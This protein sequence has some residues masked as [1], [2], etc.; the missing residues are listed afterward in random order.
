VAR[1]NILINHKTN[2]VTRIRTG[3]L[4]VLLDGGF[5]TVTLKGEILGRDVD[6]VK[7]VSD[8]K[9]ANLRQRII[10]TIGTSKSQGDLKKIFP[11]FK[12][13]DD[14]PKYKKQRRR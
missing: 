8:L 11:G 6:V 10:D 12:V 9:D 1:R 7:A 13:E 2:V 5:I 3:G 14:N 4:Q